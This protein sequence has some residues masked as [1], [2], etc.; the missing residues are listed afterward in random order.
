MKKFFLYGSVVILVVIIAI[1]I[2]AP[3]TTTVQRSIV[4]QQPVE[5]VFSYLVSLQNIEKYSPWQLKDPKA[6]HQYQGT[7][8]TVGSV[9]RWISESK[10]VGVGEQEIISIVENKE[11]ISELRFEEPLEGVSIGFLKFKPVANGTELTWGY[12][13]NYAFLESILM[14]IVDMDKVLGAD[15]EK[16]LQNIKTLLE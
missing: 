16:G 10:D 6:K 7:G 13:G 2:Y 9:H 11:I 4:I 1:G 3:K 5:N 15:F 14:M 8:N 12:Q